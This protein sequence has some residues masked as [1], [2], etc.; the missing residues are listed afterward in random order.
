MSLPDAKAL[1]KLAK[2]CRDAGIKQFKNAEFEFTLSD[3]APISNY[4]KKQV[5]TTG[6][7]PETSPIDSNFKG[8]ALTEEQLLFWSSADLTNSDEAMGS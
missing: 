1:K 2:A 8:E 7:A 5:N 6:M 4:K 3:D